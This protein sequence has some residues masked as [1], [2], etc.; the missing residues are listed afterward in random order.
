MQMLLRWFIH[1]C[2]CERINMSTR[3][4][5]ATTTAPRFSFNYIHM[6]AYAC[7]ACRQIS[8]IIRFSLELRLS[9]CVGRYML[10][11]WRAQFAC[12][13][14]ALSRRVRS[15]C[16]GGRQS[17]ARLLRG[18]AT[19]TKVKSVSAVCQQS[20]TQCVRVMRERAHL[21]TRQLR[22]AGTRATRK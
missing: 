20:A 22:S 4:R 3:T 10:H 15:E 18:Y 12:A 19:C 1:L 13:A 11:Q 7:A 16:A 8:V 5:T 6:C 9:S 2:E 14:S 17:A 21:E